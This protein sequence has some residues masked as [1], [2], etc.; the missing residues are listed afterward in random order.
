MSVY[1]CFLGTAPRRARECKPSILLE[2]TKFPTEVFVA[3]P[4]YTLTNVHQPYRV[5]SSLN[6]AQ[7]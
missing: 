7:T 3:L 2:T 5:P 4:I 6:K 1:V